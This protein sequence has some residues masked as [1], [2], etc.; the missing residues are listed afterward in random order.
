M[1]DP[2]VDAT[3]CSLD[4][5]GLATQRARYAVLARPALDAIAHALGA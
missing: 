4:R 2:T 3:E 5:D 1:L